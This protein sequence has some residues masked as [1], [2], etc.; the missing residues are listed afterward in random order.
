MDENVFIDEN[1]Y[2]SF[3]LL[4]HEDARLDKTLAALFPAH[5]RAVWRAA[6]E[7]GAVQI[8]GEAALRPA[9]RLPHECEVML[10]MAA[11]PVVRHEDACAAEDLPLDIVYE[12]SEIIVV[13]KAAGMV[14]HPGRGN[15]NGTLQSALLFHHSASAALP[16]AGIVHRLDKNTTG[17]LVAAKTE[18]ARLS[19]IMQF[20]SRTARREYLAIV[21]GIPAA[22]GLINR[23]LAPYKPGKMAVR[24]DG[25]EAITRFSV[26]RRWRGFSLLR[27]RLETG[28]THQI[29]AHLEYAGYPIAGDPDYHRRAR[30]LSFTMT[31]Q[32]LHAETLHLS[33]PTDGELHKWSAP[34]P[35]DMQT[36]MRVLDEAVA[37]ATDE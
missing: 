26:L 9:R 14:V 15:H 31:R 29:R 33:H 12:D 23:P 6:I 32:A 24:R 30:T 19:L 18:T 3:C 11:L 35:E 34:P 7:Q 2:S 21:H 22:T 17:L 25:K 13:N 36:A 20:K 28:R 27:C 4:P 37:K 16:R 1:N 8:D 5:A 10:N